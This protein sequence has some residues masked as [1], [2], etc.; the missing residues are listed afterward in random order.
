MSKLHSAFDQL[1]FGCDVMDC[2]VEQ[3]SMAAEKLKRPSTLRPSKRERERTNF[4]ICYEDLRPYFGKSLKDAEKGLGVSRS[5][6]KRA[7]RGHNI[8]RWP[9]N[10]KNKVNPSLFLTRVANKSSPGRKGQFSMSNSDP[11]SDSGFVIVEADFEGDTMKFKFLFSSGM[12][13]LEE[14]V[15]RRLKLNVTSF[16]MKYLDGEG[17]WILLACDDDLQ[18]CMETLAWSGN[19][20]VKMLVQSM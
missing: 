7:C 1:N 17:K 19:S 16:R 18:L 2:S 13:K 15:A 20:A 8:T 4:R 12:E 6:L 14:E 11:P 9:S 10:E 5:T 3:N